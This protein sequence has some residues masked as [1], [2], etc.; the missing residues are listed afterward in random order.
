[1][2]AMTVVVYGLFG[3]IIGSFLNVVIIRSHTGRSLAGRSGCLECGAALTPLMLV[4]V[5]S[6]VFQRGKCVACESRISLQYPLVE[7][8]TAAL[9]VGVGMTEMPLVPT[10]LTLMFMALIVC[11]I[12]YDMRHTIIPDEWVY[13]AALLALSMHVWSFPQMQFPISE[14][15]LV[16]LS[17][18]F[19]AAPI[20]FLWFVTR[21]R[22]IG[23]GD[24]KLALAVGWFLG[25][26]YGLISI[27]LAFVIG[28]AIS[29]FILLPMPVYAQALARWGLLQRPVN[30]AFT[31]KSEVP[32]GPFLAAGLLLV[33]FSIIF[34][35]ETVMFGW[36]GLD[37]ILA[38][39]L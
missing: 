11:I 39:S 4:P 25:V 24:A 15:I 12:A 26:G 10:I 30:K 13:V 21:G 37:F 27:M 14:A 22:G 32:F 2:L 23:L 38:G 9:F 35:I 36:L 1:M 28:A 33:W 20:F 31:M 34:D 7:L 6:W 19:V 8:A 17:G 18:P 29:V 3:L 16:L 5:I